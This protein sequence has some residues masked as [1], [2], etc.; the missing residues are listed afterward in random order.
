M[1]IPTPAPGEKKFEFLAA[2]MD[3]PT[4]N[5]EYPDT[6]QRYAVCMAQWDKDRS[7]QVQQQ[8]RAGWPIDPF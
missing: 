1:P 4:M 5:A 2:C 6:A 7:A 3:D 8:V